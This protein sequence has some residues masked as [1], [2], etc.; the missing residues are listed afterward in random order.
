VSALHAYALAFD[1][2]ELGA[3]DTL[4]DLGGG[5]GYGAAVAAEVVGRSGRVRTIELEP[6]LGRWA[7]EG[8]APYPQVEAVTADA[9]DTARWRGAEKVY[10]AFALAA[11]PD[12]WGEALAEGGRLVAPIG[13]PR[14]VQTLTLFEKTRG[15]LATRSLAPVRYVPDRAPAGE[16]Q[17]AVAEP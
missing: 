12:G 4:V 16:R 1:A 2:L 6:M 13:P 3:G 5:S 7:A 9:H 15:V 14:G 10:V 8:L 11:L 17:A